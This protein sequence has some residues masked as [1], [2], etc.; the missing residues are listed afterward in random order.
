MLHQKDTLIR[1]A[2]AALLV[3]VA[4][5]AAAAGVFGDL[6]SDVNLSVG[7][8]VRQE[9][10]FST[11]DMENPNNQGG[12]VFQDRTAARQ[13]YLPPSLQPVL[14]S[15]L[16]Q[17]LVPGSQAGT[18]GSVPL[19]F[20]DTVRRADFVP[21][22]DN[23][24]NYVVLR[25]ETEIA[26]K[27]GEHFDLIT[28][29]R[30]LYQPHV[31]DEFDARSVDGL[32][33]GITGGDPGLY[34]GKPNYF[35]YVVEGGS[36]P[37]P[38]EWTGDDYQ[39]YL[40]AFVL[41]YHTGALNLRAGNQ[42]IAW[43]Q[44]IFLRVFDVPNGLDLRRHLILDRGM[45]EFSDK[46]VPMLSLRAGYQVTD[47][48]LM[49]AYV[50]KFQPTVF[51]NPNTPYNVIPAQFTVH[52]MYEQGGFDKK[53]SG[54]LRLKADYGTWGWQAAYVNRYNPDGAFR[55]TESG[56][57]KPLQGGP[58]SLPDLVNTAYNN[59]RPM[60][61][62]LCQAN[63]DP[64]ICRKFAN[65]GE[66]LAH[67]PMEASPGGVY[68]ADEWFNYA[69]QV[70]LD[71][72]SGL[73]TAV[74]EFEG[75]QD[76]YTTPVDNYDQAYAELNTF[77]IG[78][79]GS[80]RG[81]LAR[82]Y[83]REDVFM[84]GASY[85]NESD[86]D[87]LNELIFNLEA[88][89]IPNRTFTDISLGKDFHETDEYTVSLVVDKW[90]RFFNDFPGTYLVF[91]ALTKNRSDLVGRLLDGY[92]GTQQ[93]AAPGKGGNANYLVF[94]FLQPW[95]NKLYELEFA[96]LY[97]PAGGILVQPGLRWHP[98]KGITVEGFYNYVNGNL[99]GKPSDN[100][101]STLDF[102]EEFT[103]RLSYQF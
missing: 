17:Q 41:D 21:S 89:Y 73:N 28:R 31:Y 90:H 49:D 77:F 47:D 101:I 64:A 38:L 23:D 100:L 46:R 81:H 56:V 37:N 53:L 93:Q 84:L 34:H 27:F 65:S 72:V 26:L 35:D 16:I 94:G 98:G 14:N 99:Y 92:G 83:F 58:G 6:F 11:T 8:F 102:A 36:K 24:F 33:G 79:G 70:R 67:S 18:W 82:E 87:F 32:Q 68:S 25:G 10:A 22:T 52:D 91:E 7:G 51:G 40:P 4:F 61:D 42:T 97:D 54:G 15:G 20:A 95:P 50:G 2:V 43:G 96:S 80:L 85:V 55:W 39:I 86:S 60:S 66:A 71:G 44:S 30:A 76:I 9:T 19:P 29:V 12:N 75:S 45:E 62:P 103:L 78:A 88:Q 74:T 48:I 5:D 59:K 1:S 57:N 3:V 69:G 13:A 63:Y